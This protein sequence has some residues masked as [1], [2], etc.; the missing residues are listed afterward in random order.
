[1]HYQATGKPEIDRTK[2]GLYLGKPGEVTHQIFHYLNLAQTTYLVE[3]KE[4]TNDDGVVPTTL[5]PIPPSVEDWR[6]VSV[7]PISEPITMWGVTPH[8]HLRGKSM[9]YTVTYP[10][11]REDVLLDVP[12][13]DFNWQIYYEFKEPVQLAAGSKITVKTGFDNSLKNKYNPAPEK[14]V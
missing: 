7:Y 6:V 3:G 5:P 11:G 10:D 4:L 1:M 12:R 13:F 9:K 8:L 14:E 2:L